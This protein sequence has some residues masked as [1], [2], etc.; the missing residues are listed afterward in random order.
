MSFLT[1]NLVDGHSMFRCI[2]GI[3]CLNFLFFKNAFKLYFHNRCI[4]SY[5]PKHHVHRS[6][7]LSLREEALGAIMAG[8]R[9]KT[10]FRILFSYQQDIVL[11]KGGNG[12][13]SIWLAVVHHYMQG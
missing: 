7:F 4:C 10:N 5:E 2:P 3:L 12:G 8:D 9:L 13:Y 1:K 6:P 11:H